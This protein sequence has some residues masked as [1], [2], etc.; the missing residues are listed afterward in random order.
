MDKLKNN[1]SSHFLLY[2]EISNF[3]GDDEYN[4]SCPQMKEDMMMM[5]VNNKEIYYNSHRLRIYFLDFRT[6]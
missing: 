2:T 1:H 5:M 6:K 4:D 3:L